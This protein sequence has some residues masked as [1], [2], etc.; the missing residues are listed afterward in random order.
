ME[1]ADLVLSLAAPGTMT[2]VYGR[3]RTLPQLI[4]QQG[5]SGCGSDL[6]FLPYLIICHRDRVCSAD[7]GGMYAARYAGSNVGGKPRPPGSSP[8][9]PLMCCAADTDP[10]HWRTFPPDPS[11]AP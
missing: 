10:G 5:D 2:V 9:R 8:A 11:A 1:V 6:V 4:Q 7:P 3:N